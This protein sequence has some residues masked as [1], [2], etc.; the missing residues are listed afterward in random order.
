MQGKILEPDRLAESMFKYLKGF[1][2]K[3]QLEF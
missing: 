1:S 3:F 2:F